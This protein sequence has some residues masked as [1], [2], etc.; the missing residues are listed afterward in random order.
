MY[1]C[2]NWAFDFDTVSMKFRNRKIKSVF[3]IAYDIF[4][5]GMSADI[6]VRLFYS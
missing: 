2:L 4:T 1:S 3:L 5:E 6:D